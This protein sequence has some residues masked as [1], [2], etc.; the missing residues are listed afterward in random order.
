[1]VL[2]VGA[3]PFPQ[4]YLAYAMS[5]KR[6]ASER[7]SEETSEDDR[8]V[9]K[10]KTLPHW[11]KKGAVIEEFLAELDSASGTVTQ[12]AIWA[13]ERKH[14]GPGPLNANWVR[15]LLAGLS[16]NDG[17][18]LDD[19]LRDIDS[20]LAES[21]TDYQHYIGLMATENEGVTVKRNLNDVILS[22][23][24]IMQGTSCQVCFVTG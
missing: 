9:K 4:P 24:S 18:T 12:L 1:M 3:N 7:S 15:R 2:R 20:Y 5:L 21:K 22:C 16:V 13:S 11:G 23:K 8:E 17:K 6:L 14:I 19:K 10:Q